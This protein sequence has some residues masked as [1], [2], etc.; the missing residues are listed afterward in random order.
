MTRSW[1][2]SLGNLSGILTTN[3]RPQYIPTMEDSASGGENARCALA[4]SHLV[5]V[6]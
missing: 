1:F 3:S 4:R 6:Q 2:Q 5:A